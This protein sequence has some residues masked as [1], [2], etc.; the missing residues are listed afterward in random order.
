MML[1]C[2]TA[3]PQTANPVCYWVDPCLIGAGIP[4]GAMGA[5]SGSD[6]A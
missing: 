1:I 5:G 3:R 4:G 6:K 2:P